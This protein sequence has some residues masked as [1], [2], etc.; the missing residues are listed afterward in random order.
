MRF[1]FAFVAALCVTSPVAAQTQKPSIFIDKIEEDQAISGH[2]TGLDRQSLKQYRVI[3][4]VHTDMWYIHPYAGQGE[5]QSW[6]AIHDDGTWSIQTVHRP[7]NADQ[8]AALVVSDT[9]AFPP[10]TNAIEKLNSVVMIKKSLAG[11][12]DFGKL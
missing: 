7:F 4:Y 11:T 2:V 1:V 12:P 9:Y 3:V 8:V 5:G 6:A 10:R